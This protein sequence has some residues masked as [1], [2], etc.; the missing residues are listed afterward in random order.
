M[1]NQHPRTT[2]A[3]AL[4]L[5][6]ALFGAWSAAHGQPEMSLKNSNKKRDHPRHDHPRRDYP[7]RDHPRRDHPRRDH[8]RRDY[9][10]RDH[11]RRDHSLLL[12]LAPTHGYA[13]SG[14]RPDPDAPP[15]AA[16]GRNL[17]AAARADGCT[18]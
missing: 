9:P 3:T 2:A 6:L 15:V 7:R 13:I 10:R 17:A 8:P 16:L 1:L 4:A 12:D 11:P 5:L 18:G 14:F